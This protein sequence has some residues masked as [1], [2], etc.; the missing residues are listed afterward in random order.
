MEAREV[1]AQLARS[2]G[3][4]PIDHPVRLPHLFDEA[5]SL[6]VAEML[7]DFDLRLSEDLLQVPDAQRATGKCVQN[8]QARPIAQALVNG[9]EVH[10]LYIR[11]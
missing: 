1:R 6:Q 7:R 9:S 8:A 3:R 4:Q 2:R 10:G 11:S 5:V